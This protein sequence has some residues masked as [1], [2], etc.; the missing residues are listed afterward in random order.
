MVSRLGHVHI[1]S[2]SQTRFSE[3]V[4]EKGNSF[5]FLANLGQFQSLLGRMEGMVETISAIIRF[6]IQFFVYF[7]PT[8]EDHYKIPAF[9]L[10][11]LGSE[12]HECC[13]ILSRRNPSTFSLSTQL[14]G[15]TLKFFFLK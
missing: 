11:L 14:H 5:V 10:L 2:E 6:N 12:L 4:V 13:L 1:P 15:F 7:S 8:K 3:S 9:I